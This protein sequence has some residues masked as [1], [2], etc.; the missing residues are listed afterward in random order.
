MHKK[1]HFIEDPFKYLE[2]D[3]RSVSALFKEMEE[4]TPQETLTREDLCTQLAAMLN[5]HSELEKNV[6]YPKLEALKDTHELTLEAYEEH[7]LVEALLDELAM[8][9]PGSEVW[10]AK[11]TVLKENVEH[12]VREEET[13]LFKKARA[14]LS[15]DAQQ[16]LAYD[17]ERFLLGE[18]I[19]A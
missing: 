4:T 9:N 15:K 14:A 16:A 10:T 13:Q 6:L 17:M 5:E 3:H 18:S 2:Q 1:E 19:P 11:L 8:L 12:H 7:K